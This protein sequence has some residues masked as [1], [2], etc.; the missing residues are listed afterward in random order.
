LHAPYLRPERP[1]A[2]D[3]LAAWRREFPPFNRESEALVDLLA[4]LGAPSTPSF[5]KVL[6]SACEG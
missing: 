5:D 3:E 6:I 1:E 4:S 2:F